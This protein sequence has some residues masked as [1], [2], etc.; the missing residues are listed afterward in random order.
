MSDRE[1]YRHTQIGRWQVGAAVLA[2]IIALVAAFAIDFGVLGLV[3]TISVLPILF[4]FMT[5][6]V[7]VHDAHVVLRFG[8]GIVRKRI[9][10]A[11]VS[12]CTEVRT[13]FL[14]GV[15]IRMVNR[16]WLYNVTTGGAVELTLIGGKRVLIGTD[17]P[18]RLLGAIEA[19]RAALASPA[20]S[21]AGETAAGPGVKWLVAVFAPILLVTAGAMIYQAR[22]MEVDVAAPAITIRSGFYSAS[23]PLEELRE[24]IVADSLPRLTR[25]TNGFALGNARRGHFV[26]DSLGP[27]ML[28]VTLKSP[29][30]IVLKTVNRTVIVSFRDST[31]ARI[32]VDNLSRLSGN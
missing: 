32:I 1:T 17:E 11:D 10:L 22:S 30:Y 21:A 12:A 19:A 18:A 3:I 9:A 2:L 29:P 13:T 20:R 27:A 6:T 15:G 25:R 4:S 28:F 31:K 5:L 26:V 16:G 7:M 14:D 24:V 8:Y 23:V